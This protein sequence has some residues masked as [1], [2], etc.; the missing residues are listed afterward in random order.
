M[1]ASGVTHAPADALRRSRP[2]LGFGRRRRIIVHR[3]H[4]FRSALLGVTG[5]GALLVLIFVLIS[6]TDLQSSR[7]ILQAAPGLRETMAGMRR[8]ELFLALAGGVLFMAGVFAAGLLESRKTAGPVLNLRR[9][10]EELRSGRLGARVIVRRHDNFPE[11]ADAFNDMAASL[12]AR[13]EGELATLRR[14]SQQVSD[15]L[16]EAESGNRPAVR[17]VA[18]N[19]LQVL[20]DARRRK[21]DLLEP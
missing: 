16:R 9:R 5:M 17:R 19:L 21:A 3:R 10:M 15:L 14:L 1:G 18:G 11:L 8:T 13:V 20:E 7:A 4:Q 2:L 12:R 6:R